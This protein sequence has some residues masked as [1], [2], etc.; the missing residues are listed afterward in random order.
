M[1]CRT[2]DE[3][4]ETA[5]YK[6]LVKALRRGTEQLLIIIQASRLLLCSALNRQTVASVFSELGGRQFCCSASLETCTAGGQLVHCH[7]R[8]A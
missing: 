2:P 3:V 4:A 5:T 6:A 1:L 8:P 7:A